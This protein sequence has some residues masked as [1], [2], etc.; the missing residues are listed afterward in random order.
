MKRDFRRTGSPIAPATAILFLIL[1]LLGGPFPSGTGVAASPLVRPP[2]PADNAVSPPEPSPSAPQKFS[3]EGVVVEFSYE[4]ASKRAGGVIEGEFTDLRFRVT[5]EAKGKPVRSLRPGAWMDVARPLDAAPGQEP[6]DCRKKVGLYLQGIVG[7]RPMLDLNGYF[8]VAMNREP[9]LYVIDPFIGMAGKTN[10]LTTVRLREPATDWTKSA[11]EKRLYV[12]LHKAGKVAVVDTE[13][14]KIL[15]EV[16]AGE[17]P[18]R[19]ALQPDGQVLWVGNDAPDG[20][21]GGVTAID[22]GTLGT[23]ASIPTGKGHHELAFSA[24]SR[25]AYATNR[26]SGTVSVI[27]VRERRKVRDVPVGPQPISLA[28]SAAARALFVA[29]GQAGTVTVVDGTSHEATA[30]IRAA[31]GLGPMRFT[32]DGRWGLILNSRENAVH[33]VDASSNRLAH[34]VAVGETPYQ[35]ALTRGF[36]HVRCLGTERVFMINLELLG[37]DAP[38]PV[39]SYGV[40]AEAPKDA[41]GLGIASGIAAVAGQSEVLIVNPVS[42]TLFFYMDGMNFTSGSFPGY[43][44]QPRAVET[45]N[46]SVR[47]TEPGVYT[48]RARVPVAGEYDVALFMDS[49][50]FVHCFTLSAGTNPEFRKEAGYE[51]EYLQEDRSAVLEEEFRFRFRIKETLTGWPVKGLPDARLLYYLSPGRYRT[52]VP[53]REVEEGVYEAGLRF[54]E[55]GAYNV[56]VGVPSRKIGYQT[57]IHRSLVVRKRG[58]ADGGPGGGEPKGAKGAK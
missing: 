18:V 29:D 11:D 56:H 20:S 9:N 16:D 55:S 28:Y 31:S 14:F 21:V 5:D 4:P 37:K 41:P 30:T 34:T 40:G 19:P 7:I 47:E 45:I 1:G 17:G 53:A 22:T 46:R 49:P 42:N 24:D 8:I 57:F 26:G 36:A 13:T 23:A 27:D 51:V 15:R 25:Y 54:R 32:E 35:I 3:R 33:I 12:T 6:L 52:E 48:A 43:R 44:Q 39:Q 2:T 58:A 38:P 10:L 50:R